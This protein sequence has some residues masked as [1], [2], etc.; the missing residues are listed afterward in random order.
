MLGWQLF[1]GVG[2]QLNNLLIKPVRGH[3]EH[4]INIPDLN[5]RLFA[6]QLAIVNLILC[7]VKMSYER[8]SVLPRTEDA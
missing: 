3:S 6:V 1:R 7:H 5:V 4:L 2:C 8:E